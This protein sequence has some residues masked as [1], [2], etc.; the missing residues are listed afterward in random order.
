M[1]QSASTILRMG[2]VLVEIIGRVLMLD[3]TII[4]MVLSYPNA[5]K[6]SWKLQ[7]SSML[8]HTCKKGALTITF[9]Y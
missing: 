6:F 1:I 2:A 9:D 3:V 5:K 4:C 8:E 7:Q